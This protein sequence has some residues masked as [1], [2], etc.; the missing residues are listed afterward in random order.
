ML[1]CLLKEGEP[2][3]TDLLAGGKPI[4]LNTEKDEVEELVKEVLVKTRLK[5]V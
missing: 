2:C 3:F 1:E 4:E 5:L